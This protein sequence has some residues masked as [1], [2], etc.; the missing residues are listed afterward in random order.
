MYLYV[1]INIQNNIY[2]RILL[3]FLVLYTE[4]QLLNR[5]GNNGC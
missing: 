1:N 4:C 2:G 5:T 3:S